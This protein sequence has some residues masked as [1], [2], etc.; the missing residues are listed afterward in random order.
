MKTQESA[1][2]ALA[3][4]L[5]LISFAFLSRSFCSLFAFSSGVS[6][7]SDPELAS[8]S[9]F[10]FLSLVS[11]S[12][13]D[14][15]F[16][17]FLPLFLPFFLSAFLPRCLVFFFFFLSCWEWFHGGGTILNYLHHAWAGVDVHARQENI[18]SYKL[19]DWTYLLVC[20][21]MWHLYF[22]SN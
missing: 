11:L 15:S 16:L 7:V 19:R 5:F 13:F 18:W 2:L 14:L 3:M 17:S 1:L 20:I 6:S 10:F 4:R 22:F 8:E 12:F 21:C 9:F